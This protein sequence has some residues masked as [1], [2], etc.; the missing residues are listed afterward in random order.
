MR[1]LIC[2]QTAASGPATFL[3]FMP[4]QKDVLVISRKKMAPSQ[5]HHIRLLTVER[6]ILTVSVAKYEMS[7][8]LMEQADRGQTAND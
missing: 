1:T 7:P 8:S 2:W 4:L 3:A 5:P 6:Q